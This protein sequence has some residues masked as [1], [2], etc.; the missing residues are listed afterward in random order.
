MTQTDGADTAELARDRHFFAPGRK[1][2]LS[3]DGGG[4]RGVLAIAFLERLEAILAESAGW[5]VRLCD[6][7]IS[8]AARRRAQSLQPR[9]RLAILRATSAI[10]TSVSGR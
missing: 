3:I 9:S 10:S 1:R 6:H 8:S 7:S 2:I 5:P 4:V